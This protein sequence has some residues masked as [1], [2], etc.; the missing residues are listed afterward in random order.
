MST[1]K[2]L[3]I[4]KGSCHKLPFGLHIINSRIDNITTDP[5]VY[6]V[7]IQIVDNI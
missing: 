1:F 4:C 6:I 5:T 7:N 2:I 3:P